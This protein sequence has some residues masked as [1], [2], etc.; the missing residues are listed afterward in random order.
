MNV[1]EREKGGSMK[2]AEQSIKNYVHALFLCS[3]ECTFCGGRVEECQVEACCENRFA[4]E[5][6]KLGWREVKS[7]KYETF[8]LAC[9]ACV[10][11]EDEDR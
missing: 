9:P 1:N 6:M 2:I 3:V 4:V 8:G 5:L 7:D 10:S 11:K